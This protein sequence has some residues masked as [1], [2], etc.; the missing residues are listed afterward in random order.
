LEGVFQY[1]TTTQNFEK[2]ETLS[3]IYENDEY[4]TG[5]LVPE[6]ND[7]LWAFTNN[8]I[9]YISKEKLSQNFKIDRIAISEN[10]RNEKK[11]YENISKI[12]ED[13]YLLGTSAGYL[14]IDISN[15]IQKDYKV[16]MSQVVNGDKNGNVKLVPTIAEKKFQ[17]NENYFVFE[18]SV[19]KFDKYFVTEYQYCLNGLVDDKWSDWSTSS[20][21]S[22][23]NLR[24]GDYEFKVKAR[25]N[26][27]EVENVAT[28]SF[29]IGRPWYLSNLALMAYLVSV[30]IIFS[31]INAYYKRSYK[32]Q[33]QRIMD[34]ASKE[35]EVKEL[36][37]QKEIIQLKNE[38][39]KQDIE[40]RNRELAI[41]TMSMIKKNN[42]LNEIKEE[43]IGLED[44]KTVKPV[45]N[46][47]NK[48]MNDQVDWEFF[49]EAFNHA[50]KDFFKKV[51]E[52]HPQLTANDLRLCVYLRL[53]LSSKEIAP[54]LN[55][56]PRSVEIKRYRLRKKIALD[57]ETNL[58]DYFINL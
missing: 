51:K 15:T 31:L 36:E 10:L 40:A 23:E 46:L 42:A 7:R 9:I 47:I 50:D 43:L 25:V 57:R 6:G 13:Q 22:F 16:S 45:V 20:S 29:E 38:S 39:L 3:T 53:N 35:M 5:R 21:K 17:S 32:Q 48:T 52:I 56:S 2:N 37:T 28:Y 33:R 30:V 58:N 54:L 41:S 1:N 12:R 34:K 14:L 4:V 44:I 11:G 19:P 55:I 26:K 27:R 24:F 8:Y 49:E 18:Y